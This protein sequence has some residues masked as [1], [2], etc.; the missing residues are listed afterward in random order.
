MARFQWDHSAAPT[1]RQ[2]RGSSLS[3]RDGAEQQCSHSQICYPHSQ[4]A[5]PALGV[6]S[7]GIAGPLS[8][9][10]GGNQPSKEPLM[11]VQVLRG[12]KFH[13]VP[14]KAVD[15]ALIGTEWA[16]AMHILATLLPGFR[17]QTYFWDEHPETRV[18]WTFTLGPFSLL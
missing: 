18:S 4:P 17:G 10:S 2:G 15:K 16:E 14:E 3:E 8:S 13:R 5:Y 11:A 12:K 9:Q 6:P 7:A 1:P